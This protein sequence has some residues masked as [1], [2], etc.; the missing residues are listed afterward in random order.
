MPSLGRPR[1]R[2]LAAHLKAIARGRTRA[3]CLIGV[4]RAAD[5]AA[6]LHARERRRACRADRVKRA[7]PLAETR[8]EHAGLL[9]GDAS[10]PI[11]NTD[12]LPIAAVALTCPSGVG[13]PAGE[14]NAR[15][16]PGW[17]SASRSALPVM[18]GPVMR[19]C[20]TATRRTGGVGVCSERAFGFAGASSLPAPTQWS[21]SGAIGGVT[22]NPKP[23]RCATLSW[24]PGNRPLCVC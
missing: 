20:P 10:Q 3:A 16:H 15:P 13:R 18:R 4:R 5:P 22:V 2:S 12:G 24:F 11:R 6:Q 8:G 19:R 17:F 21:I 14:T 9:Y 23:G 7:G 1:L